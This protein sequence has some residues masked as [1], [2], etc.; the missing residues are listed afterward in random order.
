MLTTAQRHKANAYA[1]YSNFRVGAAVLGTSG[2]VYGGSNVENASFGLTL[3]GERVAV[4]NAAAEGERE[5]TAVR[6]V[7]SIWRRGSDA[8]AAG[9]H[10]LLRSPHWASDPREH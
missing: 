8:D 2:K 10:L 7:L 4:C 5:V 9:A 1:P 6:A 3:C